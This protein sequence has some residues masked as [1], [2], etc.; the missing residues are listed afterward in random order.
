MSNDMQLM[1]TRHISRNSAELEQLLRERAH[2]PVT[3]GQLLLREHVISADTLRTA[4]LMQH[5]APT[6]KLGEILSEMGALTASQAE[7]A[8]TA[9]LELPIVRLAEFDF[10]P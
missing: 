2:D 5:N 6:K 10:D 9:T 3:L 7:D 8:I 4:L 1:Y